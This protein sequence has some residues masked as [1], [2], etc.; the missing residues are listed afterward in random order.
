MRPEIKHQEIRGWGA[1]AQVGPRRARGHPPGGA[2][3][4]PR[5]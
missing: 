3:Y 2:V 1:A 4:K 5:L